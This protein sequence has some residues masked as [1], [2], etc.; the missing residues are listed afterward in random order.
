MIKKVIGVLVMGLLVAALLFGV[1]SIFSREPA[2]YSPL[3]EEEGI[4]V[5]FITPADKK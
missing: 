1:F 4:N 2:F 3:P 5:I